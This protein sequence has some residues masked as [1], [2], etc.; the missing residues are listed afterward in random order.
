M[1]HQSG[2]TG[3]CSGPKSLRY[4]IRPM[5]TRYTGSQ[6][7]A[8]RSRS[9][10]TAFSLKM[11]FAA[12][13]REPSRSARPSF[14]SVVQPDQRMS[15][16]ATTKASGARTVPAGARYG[17]SCSGNRL[18]NAPKASGAPAYMSTLALV[19]RPTSDFQL[20]NGRKQMQP[21]MKATISPNHGTP[22]SF[23]FSNA[24]GTYP[25]LL[26]PYAT[27]EVDVV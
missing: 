22:R 8:R 26:S 20:G 16:L 21:T 24:V 1:S 2:K 12:R 13:M 10:V 6:L 17:R 25:F 11:R 7:A 9:G 14:Q 23:V 15:R 19:I 5:P 3:F 18:R 27:R 4:T